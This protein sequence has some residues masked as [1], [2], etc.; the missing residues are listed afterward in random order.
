VDDDLKFADEL[1]KQMV[2]VVPGIA[3]GTPGYFRIAYCVEDGTSRALSPVF[4]AVAQKY[5][6]C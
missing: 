2:L 3:F 1:R 5:G 4:K 6:M